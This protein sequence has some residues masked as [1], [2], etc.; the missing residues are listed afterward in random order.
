[1]RP[2]GARERRL[3]ALGILIAGVGLVWLALIGPVVGGFA[4]RAA[5]RDQLQMAYRRNLR[6]IGALKTWRSAAEAQRASA[7]RFAI[8]APSEQVALAALK[9]RVERLVAQEGASLNS[10]QDLQGDATPHTVKVR[11]DMQATLSGLCD[12]LVRLQGDGVYVAVDHIWITADQAVLTG[13]A[14][15]MAVRLE[16]TAD[17]D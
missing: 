5:Q 9:E 15:P 6:V 1:M 17:Y 10:I 14:A 2:L 4:A 16:L 13:K 3:L 12:A 11:A 7:S 8:A